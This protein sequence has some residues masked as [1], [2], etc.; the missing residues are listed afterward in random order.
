MTLPSQSTSPVLGLL[1]SFGLHPDSEVLVPKHPAR[2][3]A[4]L[5][6]RSI[7]TLLSESARRGNA[8]RQARGHTGSNRGAA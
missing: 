6:E 3:E 8:G 1:R 4:E 5:S 7:L 2:W